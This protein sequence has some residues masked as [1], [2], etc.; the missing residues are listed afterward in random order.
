MRSLRQRRWLPACLAALAVLPLAATS[1]AAPQPRTYVET[2]DF[3]TLRIGYAVIARNGQ[4]LA[5]PR[6]YRTLDAGA[7]WAAVPG[8]LPT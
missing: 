5:A 7:Q 2:V 4:G 3:V 6:L 1:S 8:G